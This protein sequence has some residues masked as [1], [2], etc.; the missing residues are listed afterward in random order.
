M[1][2]ETTETAAEKPEASTPPWGNDFDAARAWTLVQNLRTERDDLKAKV[3]TL[4]SERQARED[5]GKTAEQ[6]ATEALAAAQEKAVAAERAL[7]VER[8]VRKHGLADDLVEFLTGAT[9]EEIAAKAERLAKIGKPAASVESTVEAAGSDSAPTSEDIA[10]GK[11]KPD[12]APGHGGGVAA[13]FDPVALASR[14]R[15]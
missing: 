15:C 6:K 13:S 5:E 3:G 11:P 7:F 10:L 9:E 1:A 14:A 4:E 12:L 8:A 2:E